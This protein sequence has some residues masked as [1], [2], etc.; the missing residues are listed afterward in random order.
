M[1]AHHHGQEMMAPQQPRSEADEGP[2]LPGPTPVRRDHPQRP[3][4]GPRLDRLLLRIA[5]VLGR[6]LPRPDEEELEALARVDRG[7]RPEGHALP[8]PDLD[9]AR[10]A[11]AEGRYGEALHQFGALIALDA[12][13]AWAWHGRGDA[14]QWMGQ[15]G[16]ALE[17]YGRASELAP[18]VG[19]HLAGQANALAALGRSAEAQQAWT[20]ALR[21]DPSL[22]WMQ[23]GRQPAG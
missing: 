5:R 10:R 4:W 8:L 21:L 1:R 16:H 13:N 23:H 2:R 12:D 19:L 20:E 3:T 17:A 11:L 22:T 14:L 9:R 6:L 7:P 15:P 18:G